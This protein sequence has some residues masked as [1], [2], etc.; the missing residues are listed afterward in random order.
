MP[1]QALV[2]KE[3]TPENLKIKHMQ[4]KKFNPRVAILMILMIAAAAMRIPNSAQITPWAS[5]TPIG[6][7]GLF[8]G[9]YFTNSWKA[10]AFPLI[11]LLASDLIINYVVFDGKYGIM[12]N[13]WY[14]I[15]GIF[16]LIVLLG[17]WM[18][19]N[20][21]IK[22][23]VLASVIAALG[24]WLI[25]DFTV[26]IGGGTDLRTMAPLTRDWAGLIQCY[27]QGFPFMKHFLIGNLVYSIILFG[28]FEL[29]QIRFPVLK[30]K[31]A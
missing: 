3:L 26:W 4:T 27:A 9:A 21:T 5:Y 18:L 2:C 19:Q 30:L 8:G 20:I 28:G 24:H 7:M 6:A 12:Y 1:E 10:F 11:T 29:A 16:M 31:V 15:Y 25:A 14:I 13:G 22:N 17:K 23:V